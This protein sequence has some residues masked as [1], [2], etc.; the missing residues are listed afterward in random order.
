MYKLIA[1]DMDGT[2]LNSDHA[3]TQRVINAVSAAT[4]KGVHIVLASGR[5]TA[6]MLTTLSELGL[7]TDE[8][9]ML[10][11]NGSLSLKVASQDVLR[12]RMLTAQDAVE[13]QQLARQLGVNTHAFCTTNGLITPTHNKYADI[14]GS[15]NAVLV[16]ELD[17]QQLNP[18]QSIIKVL[19]TAEPEKIDRLKDK[20]PQAFIDKYM[21]VRSAGIFLEFLHKDS[22]KG[23]AVQALTEHLG[24]RREQVICIG[25]QGNDISM[26]EYAGVGVAM[27][28]AGD[29]IKA[30]ANY[31]TTSNDQ[32]G[33]AHV[34]EKFILNHR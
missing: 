15:T 28:N 25:D 23:A 11:Y 4:E 20:I 24:L 8:H 9:Y 14:E 1:I 34:L 29:E 30:V 2:L 12:S 33:V 18:Q 10:A 19:L 6:G 26:M 16:T 3:L 17:Y 31:I 21:V 22:G 32:H 27:G 7:T 13:L 5:P